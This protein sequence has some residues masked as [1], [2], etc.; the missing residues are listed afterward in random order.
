MLFCWTWLTCTDRATL[1]AVVYFELSPP[2][3][4]GNYAR[5]KKNSLLRICS[6][7]DGC[8]GFCSQYLLR[9]FWHF[10]FTV[11]SLKL[12]PGVQSPANPPRPFDIE[13]LIRP[14]NKVGG[15]QFK[16]TFPQRTSEFYHVKMPEANPFYCSGEYF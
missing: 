1:S 5:G 15:K 7:L 9:S 3:P 4:L 6:R 10:S 2:V 11:T 14:D 16:E 8:I 12:E 13:N